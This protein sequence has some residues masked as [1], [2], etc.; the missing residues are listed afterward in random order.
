LPLSHDNLF[1]SVLGVMDVK[2]Q[3][4]DA[5]LDLFAPCGGETLSGPQAG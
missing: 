2:T 1:H 5:S 3:V 4:R